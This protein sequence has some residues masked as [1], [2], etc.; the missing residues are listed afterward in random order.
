M[1][2]SLYAI[3]FDCADAAKLASF[4][5]SVLGQAVDDGATAEFAS[6]GL[7]GEA[8]S[9][10]HWMFVKV[11]E[12]KSAKNRA[13]VDLIAQDLDRVSAPAVARR[14]PHRRPAG[15]RLQIDHTGRPRRERVRRHRLARVAVV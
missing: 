10:P 4:W 7:A 9:R 12:A 13:H 3:T 1:G 11:P 6:I 2:A 15:G 14:Q 5:S 8:A